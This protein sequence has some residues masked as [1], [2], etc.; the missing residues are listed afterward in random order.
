MTSPFPG[1]SLV[2]TDVG[3]IT[4][5]PIFAL[6]DID[7]RA[8][9]ATFLPGDEAWVDVQLYPLLLEPGEP[10]VVVS[11]VVEVLA[12]SGELVLTEDAGSL[13]THAVSPGT[14]VV[15]SSLTGADVVA[16][17]T[18]RLTV[19]CTAG[20]VQVQQVKLR[21][22]PVGGP[23]GGFSAPY[24]PPPTSV[25]VNMRR[26]AP[27]TSTTTDYVTAASMD[28]ALE[29]VEEHLGGTLSAFTVGDPAVLIGPQQI[30][31]TFAATADDAGTGGSGRGSGYIGTGVAYVERASDP[32]VPDPAGTFG[33]DWIYPPNEVPSDPDGWQYAGPSVWGWFQSVATVTVDYDPDGP[34][35]G[36]FRIA[37]EPRDAVDIPATTFYDIVTTANVIAGIPATPIAPEL[38]FDLPP[39]S[40]AGMLRLAM[41]HQAAEPND[42]EPFM[43]SGTTPTGSFITT[44]DTKAVIDLGRYVD[45][46]FQAVQA[47]HTR[48]Y[49]YWTPTGAPVHK[50]RQYHRDDGLGIAPRR[51]YGGASRNKTRRAYGYT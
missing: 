46:V 50:L 28:L 15:A 36:D 10:G 21:V 19:S 1:E 48:P 34:T 17:G 8:G 31:A 44:G 3:N 29:A 22:W 51:A 40:D 26:V 35:P 12:G 45:G 14:L 2:A 49:R 39:L 5:A 32:F 24:T 11:W 30:A 38:E 27:D 13:G 33:V 16:G 18:A 47:S 41:W 23:L 7:H 6:G 37:A 20:P 4:G 43:Q 25:N 9:S 42:H